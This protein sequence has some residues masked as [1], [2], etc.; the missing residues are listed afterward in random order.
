MKVYELINRLM[1]CSARADVEIVMSVADGYS[2]IVTT[3][4][5]VD[6]DD[7]TVSIYSEGYK[8]DL[9]KKKK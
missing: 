8:P 5:F 9:I 6:A 1:E 7:M 4:F 2:N 3:D